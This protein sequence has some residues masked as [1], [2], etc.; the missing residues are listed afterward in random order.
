MYLFANMENLSEEATFCGGFTYSLKYV[1]GP[2]V[3]QNPEN[4]FSI[5]LA[6]INQHKVVGRPMDL[7]WIGTHIFVM[8]GTNGKLNI[9]AKA[10]GNN[11]FFGNVLSQQL[12]VEIRDPCLSTVLDPEQIFPQ[13]LVIS[14]PLGERS[15]EQELFGPKDSVSISYGNGYDLCGDRAFN[16]YRIDGSPYEQQAKNALNLKKIKSESRPGADLLQL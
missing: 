4:S 12:T 5:E 7:K 3:G 2:M 16:V 8:Q 10:R 6:N 1:Q 14:V 9:S 13:D 11:G 15:F